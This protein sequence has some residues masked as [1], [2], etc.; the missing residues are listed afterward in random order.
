MFARSIVAV[1]II[2][3][4]ASAMNAVFRLFLLRYMK[5]ATKEKVADERK[6]IIKP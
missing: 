3:A 5:E 6:F 2:I 4:D 1:S